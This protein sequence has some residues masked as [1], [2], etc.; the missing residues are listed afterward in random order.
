M[1]LG[2]LIFHWELSKNYVLK[3]LKFH[4]HV[5]T[6]MVLL[7]TKIQ[8]A[9]QVSYHLSL[10]DNCQTFYSHIFGFL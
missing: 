5:I 6:Y 1:H 9:R 4:K 3:M 10:T 7:L 8:S 2:Q